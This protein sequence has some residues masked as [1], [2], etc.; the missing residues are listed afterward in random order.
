MAGQDD[1][2]TLPVVFL[3]ETGGS[4]LRFRDTDEL[5]WVG[6]QVL[7]SSLLARGDV[8]Q[9]PESLYAS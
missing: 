8:S 3:P 6:P 2:G 5:Y 9:Q 1:V 7:R 4:A